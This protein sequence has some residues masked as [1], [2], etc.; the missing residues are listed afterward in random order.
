MVILLY[1][2]KKCITKKTVA[3]M[4]TLF[5]L[6]IVVLL[7]Y[8]NNSLYSGVCYKTIQQAYD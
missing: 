5:L 6:H 3:T 8:C 4:V 1:E 7:V 2:I